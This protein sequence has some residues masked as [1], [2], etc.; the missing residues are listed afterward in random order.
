MTALMCEVTDTLG[1]VGKEKCVRELVR[2]MSILDIGERRT[3]KCQIQ[4]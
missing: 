4:K 2:S 3:C 1:R